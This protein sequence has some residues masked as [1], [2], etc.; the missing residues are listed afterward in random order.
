MSSVPREPLVPLIIQEIDKNASQ[1]A[2]GA[3]KVTEHENPMSSLLG[4]FQC[5][6][7]QMPGPLSGFSMTKYKV[8]S[9][10]IHVDEENGTHL[11]MDIYPCDG[12]KQT[13]TA[14]DFDDGKSDFTAPDADDDIDRNDDEMTVDVEEFEGVDTDAT[15]ESR[16]SHEKSD[17]DASL[18][19]GKIREAPTIIEAMKA[20][21]DLQKKLNPPRKTGNGHLDPKINPFVRTRMEGMRCLLNFF[22]NPR[23][24]THAHWGASSL[25]A[26]IA[27]GRG[28]HC[29]RQLRKLARQF[30]EDRKILPVNPYGEWNQ[31]MLVNKDLASDINLHLQELSKDITAA[32]IV[33]FLA[34]PDVKLKHG[35]TKK[36]SERTARRYLQLLGYR[37]MTAKKGQYADGHERA[38]VVWYRDNRF[39]PKMKDLLARERVWT[40]D[41]EQVEGPIPGRRVVKWYHDEAIF[42]A[43][44]RNKR[45]WYHKDAAAKPYKKGEGAS[46]MV[47]ELVSADFGW[48]QSPDGKESVRVVMKPG[49]NKDGYFTSDEIIAQAQKAMDICKKYW[50]EYEHVFIYDNAPTHLTRPE[51]SLSARR[52]PKFTPKV[53]HNWG[54]EVTK[55]DAEGKPVYLPNGSLEKIKIQMCDAQFED[56]RPQPLYFP[57]GHPRAGVF[58]GMATILEER[59]FSDMSKVI[60]ECK[61]FKCA[62]PAID[63]CCR[64]ILYNQPDFTHVETILET[65]C[66]NQ[67]FQVIFL[68]KFHCELNFI[69]QCW[70]YAKRL[71]RLNPESSQEA[72]LEKNTITALN[73]VPLESMRR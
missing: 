54:I 3:S 18:R 45:G 26:S 5:H 35:I 47:A 60:A 59:G 10:P 73:A 20:L 55:R 16:T 24:T 36:I 64:R 40:N 70:G 62:P 38:D 12:H 56:G 58:K 32:K 8:I 29:A 19:D 4:S 44:D 50:P 34:R 1:H 9:E 2:P 67:G 66:K 49:K 71:Y 7:P 39:L 14:E 69:E 51:D 6:F 33:K 42:Y 23:S 30:I 37:W 43:H 63:C 72:V 22:T 11:Y 13:E 68:P 48:L 57:E 53:G 46:L 27:L 65:Y 15:D 17:I 28:V 21:A 31:T 52:M 25:Q 61:S 41:N